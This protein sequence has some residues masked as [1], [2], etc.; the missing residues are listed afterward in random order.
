M[1]SPRRM[2]KMRNGASSAILSLC[3]HWNR[4]KKAKPE[5][6]ELHK[7]IVRFCKYVLLHST[8]SQTNMALFTKLQPFIN[9][10]LFFL[11][12]EHWFILCC[13]W[14]Q[15]CSSLLQASFFISW[16]VCGRQCWTQMCQMNT[17][18]DWQASIALFHRVWLAAS[19]FCVWLWDRT[20]KC[21]CW[22]VPSSYLAAANTHPVYWCTRA[23]QATK[24]ERVTS[25]AFWCSSRR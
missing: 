3:L 9:V 1:V 11:M 7:A 10:T 22:L 20:C 18:W 16:V 25:A 4:Q 2:P 14:N 6:F 5:S 17:G 24:L 12:P 15:Q 13:S 8:R 23:W 21:A 19:S